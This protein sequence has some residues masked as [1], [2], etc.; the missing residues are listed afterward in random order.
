ME[1][2]F[3]EFCITTRFLCYW[4]LFLMP[5]GDSNEDLLKN[6]LVY[7]HCCATHRKTPTLQQN[8]YPDVNLNHV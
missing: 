1:L 4:I 5:D 6:I 7:N 3:Y 2:W 8:V